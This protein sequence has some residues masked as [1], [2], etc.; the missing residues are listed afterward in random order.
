MDDMEKKLKELLNNPE[1]LQELK[2]LADS[3]F[4]EEP[5][6]EAEEKTNKTA[7]KEVSVE[8]NQFEQPTEKD[9]I[10]NNVL[11]ILSQLQNTDNSQSVNK[12]N[13]GANA[14]NNSSLPN[15]ELILK[16]GKLFKT[17][18]PDNRINLLLALKPH[19]SPEKRKRVDSAVKILKIYDILPLLKESGILDSLLN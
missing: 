8:K 3:V 9:N 12:N 16:A 18:K 14:Q 15:A 7:L 11:N 13:N 1:Q 6:K 10:K 4:A 2:A 17:A 19:L 5:K